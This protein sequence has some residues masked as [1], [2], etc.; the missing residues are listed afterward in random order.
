M[1]TVENTMKDSGE[2]PEQLYTSMAIDSDVLEGRERMK[3]FSIISVTE[4]RGG[5]VLT[6]DIKDVLSCLIDEQW[7]WEVK[8]LR[9]G[10]FIAP[11][12]T[13]A[14]ARQTEKKSPLKMLSFTLNFEPWTPDLWK[15]GRADGAIR[16]VIVK[17]L[18]M[19]CW[20]R[21]LVARLLKPSGDLVYV[22]GRSGEYGD[23]LRL[24]LRIRK[25]RRLPASIHCNLGTRQYNYTIEMERGQPSLPWGGRRCSGPGNKAAAA[26]DPGDPQDG[27]PKSAPGKEPATKEGQRQSS[28]GGGGECTSTATRHQKGQR[29]SSHGG[30][31]RCSG[32]MD[33]TA[34]NRDFHRGTADKT[35]LQPTTK[36][37]SAPGPSRQHRSG[38]GPP[39]QQRSAPGP[40]RQRHSGLGPPRQ[41]RSAHGPPYNVGN[42]HADPAEARRRWDRRGGWDGRWEA[43]RGDGIDR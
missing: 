42:R 28:H 39:R 16:W 23:D 43:E 36:P 24:L 15:K 8:E 9:D 31:G 37:N 3:R 32:E 19:D 22:D 1:K 12:P 29:Q 2:E 5:M 27:E 18:P 35:G 20:S 11:F 6:S 4:K 21:D 41:Q 17:Q 40:P 38:L 10:R 30:G 14:L 25:P 26:H 7:S 34:T 33:G 13:V